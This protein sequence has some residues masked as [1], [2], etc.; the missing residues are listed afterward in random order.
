MKQT[1]KDKLAQAEST[2][3]GN[4][5]R[6]TISQ[7]IAGRTV[8]S[9]IQTLPG[10]EKLTDGTTLG[11]HIFGKLDGITIIRVPEDAILAANK[12]II[13]W[14]GLSPFEAPVVYAPYMPLVVTSTLPVAPNP[15]QQMKAA[16]VWAG[17]ESLVPNFATNFEVLN[18]NV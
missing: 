9:I 15:L 18:P 16:A 11:V 14:K 2:L 1:F 7:I 5:G 4:A 12:A 17:I 13:T 3:I 6:G 10:F 8:C